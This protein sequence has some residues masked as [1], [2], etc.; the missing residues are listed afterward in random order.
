[1]LL[2]KINYTS[3]LSNT[4][5]LKFTQKIYVLASK[6]FNMTPGCYSRHFLDLLRY[7]FIFV[8]FK[9]WIFSLLLT[10]FWVKQ[11]KEVAGNALYVK[12]KLR[13]LVTKVNLSKVVK[14]VLCNH[15]KISANLEKVF[16]D[17]SHNFKQ[18]SGTYCIGKNWLFCWSVTLL[19]DM[20]VL[21]KHKTSLF[22]PRYR[23]KMISFWIILI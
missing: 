7:W 6:K 8:L 3:N 22:K 11:V 16:D 18:V 17:C 2:T 20:A 12:R 10:S 21:S 15:P 4:L 13:R 9:K 1:M 5:L 14:P 19:A 23:S